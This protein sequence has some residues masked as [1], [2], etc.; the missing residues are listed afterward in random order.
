MELIA[1]GFVSLLGQVVLLRELN[2]AFYGSELIYVLA[3]GVWMA[4]T[5][6]GALLGPITTPRLRGGLLVVAFVL[7]ATVVAIRRLRLLFGAVPGAYL[8]FPRQLLALAL[9]LAPACLLLGL[10]FQWAARRRGLA[11]AYGI[12]SIGAALGGLTSTILLGVGWLNLQLGLLCSLVALLAARKPMALLLLAPL[13]WSFLNAPSLDEA[14]TRWNHPHLLASRDSPY[15]RITLTRRGGQLTVFLNDALAWETQGTEAE[16]FANLAA[17]Q[18]ESPGRMLVLGG[19]LEGLVEQ[20]QRHH[21]QELEYVELNAVLVDMLADAGVRIPHPVVGDPRRAL[22]G[23]EGDW[24]LILVGMPEPDSGQSNR[25]YTQEFF[26]LC[27]QRLAPAGVL[28]FQLPGAE[29]LWTPWL[30]LRL[31][32]I[33]SALRAVFQHVVVLPGAINTLLASASPLPLDPHVLGERLTA[34]HIPTRLMSPAYLEYT[35]TNDRFSEIE[36]L[37]QDTRAPANRDTHPVCYSYTLLLWLARFFPSLTVARIPAWPAG[38]LLLP[39]VVVLGMARRRPALRRVSLAFLAGLSGMI[40]E[41]TLILY[42]QTSRGVLYRDLGLLLTLFMA[43]LAAGAF[44]M[45]RHRP[46]GRLVLG[47]MVVLD[48]GTT[49]LLHLGWAEGLMI[50]GA[51]LFAG[52]MGTASLFAWASRHAGA[53]PRRVIAPLYAADLLGGCLGALLAVIVL[54]PS[55]GLSGALLVLAGLAALAIPVVEAGC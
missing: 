4:W 39:L 45:T 18:R 42:Y 50:T 20:L 7:P 24:D 44:L 3:L 12:E 25:F 23:S 11:R 17:L 38:L 40:L 48:L 52:G 54:V 49:G 2:V 41:S 19:G 29:N 34:R 51:L 5:A 6:V 32:S 46:S 22:A 8:S 15:G 36:R 43:G 47:A 21:P 37:L 10:L 13:G 31:A 55:L 53:D 26:A 35:Y 1:I 33:H 27:Q 28:A 9:C 14:L 16:E 30:A